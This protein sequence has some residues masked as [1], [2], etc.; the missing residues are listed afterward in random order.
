MP[1]Q[2]EMNARGRYRLDCEE[3]L[4]SIFEK[5]V[6]VNEVAFLSLVQ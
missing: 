2:L 5:G 4:F 3:I 6:L 1:I